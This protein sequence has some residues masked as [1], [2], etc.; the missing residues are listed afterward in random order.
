MANEGRRC[1]CICKRD[2]TLNIGKEE[3][4]LFECGK[5]YPCTIRKHFLHKDQYKI[6]GKEYALSCSKEKFD[7]YFQLKRSRYY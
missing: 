7:E 5:I 2:L 3:Q 4:R 6:Y 1:E